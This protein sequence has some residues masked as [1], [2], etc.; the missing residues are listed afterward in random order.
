LRILQG[1]FTP[2]T[3]I[4]SPPKQAKDPAIREPAAESGGEL[5]SDSAI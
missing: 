2:E 3:V 4:S 5:I 1:F